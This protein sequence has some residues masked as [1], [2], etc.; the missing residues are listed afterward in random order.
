MSED[1]S[2]TWSNSEIFLLDKDKKPVKVSG[3]PPDAFSEVG[4]LWGNPIYNWELLEQRG[5]DWWIE[6]FKINLKLYDVLRLDHFRGFESYWEVT[7]GG[8][9][10]IG[11]KWEK[12]PGMKFFK[13]INKSL[14][15]IPIIIEDLGY[16]TEGVIEL[17]EELGYPGMKILQFAFDSNESN[18]YLPHNY[19]R[20]CVVYTGTHDNDTINGWINN[21]NN[22]VVDF[23]N[24]YLGLNKEEKYN[25][26]LI[27]GAWSSTANLS[28]AQLQDFLEIGSE[29]RINTPSTT[30]GNWQWR[31]KKEYLT[32]KLAEKIYDI[33]KIYGRNR[34]S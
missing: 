12:G 1:S 33:T 3:C 27:R 15:N 22:Y 2:D 13:A 4:Q 8:K 24:K 34:K 14:G 11:G 20:N 10:A 30:E 25:L 5:F 23:A 19:N 26:G 28:I 29:G 7:Y 32:E 17:R 18:P 16:L 31:L 6:R 21:S 9:T